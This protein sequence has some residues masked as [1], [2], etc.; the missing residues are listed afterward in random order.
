MLHGR[1]RFTAGNGM[2]IKILIDMNLSPDWVDEL[3]KLG[4]SAES[5]GEFVQI[6]PRF[7]A[8]PSLGLAHV[9]DP[10]VLEVRRWTLHPP[11]RL[12]SSP[13]SRRSSCTSALLYPP[14][15]QYKRI[16]YPGSWQVFLNDLNASLRFVS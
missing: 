16:T 4:S 14:L 1:T 8:P 6:G 12:R 3:S 5:V 9:G 10:E 2:N 13:L 11:S 15:R 7:P